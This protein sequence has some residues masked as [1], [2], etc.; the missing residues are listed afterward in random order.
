M[1][2][3]NVP[4]VPV[5]QPRPRAVGRLSKGKVVARV[6][7]HTSIKQ[8]DG[9]RKPHPIVAFKATCRMAAEQAY[10]GPPLS[11]PVVMRLMFVMPRPNNMIWKSKPM[12]VVEHTKKPDK[13]NLEKAVKDAL[14]GIVWVDDSQ[15]WASE[16]FKVIA[17]GQEQ[18]HVSIKII[19]QTLEE[20]AREHGEI[21]EVVTR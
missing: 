9:S 4:A 6:H 16:V 12:D 10:N 17:S 2:T 21:W 20:Y 8:A 18:P 1:I 5:A 19:E 14:T 7:E 15:V 3:I 11:G 13:D